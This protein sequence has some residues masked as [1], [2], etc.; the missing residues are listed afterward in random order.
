MGRGNGEEGKGKE[1]GRGRDRRR[2]KR[3]GD[4]T[5]AM[6]GCLGGHRL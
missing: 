1:V 5:D 3:K 2:G 6:M 4:F